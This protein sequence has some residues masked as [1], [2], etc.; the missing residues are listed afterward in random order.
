MAGGSRNT[1]WRWPLLV[2]LVA[3]TVTGVAA[4][5][6]WFIT[7]DRATFL[8]DITHP[9]ALVD[10]ALAT[11]A[12][13]WMVPGLIV[14]RRANWHP[15]GWMLIAT[16]LGFAL[17]FDMGVPEVWDA[18]GVP[19]HW[20]AWVADGWGNSVSVTF[21]AALLTVFPDGI[22]REPAARRWAWIRIV[23]ATVG[24]VASGLGTTV[25]GHEDATFAAA[26]FRNPTGLG[27]IPQAVAG[28]MFLLILLSTV[29][30]AVSLWRR[31]RHVGEAEHGRYT[32]VLFPFALM[33]ASILLAIPLSMVVGDAVWLA[34][35]A[36]YFMVPIAFSIAIVRQRLFDIDRVV[37][38]T[39]TYGVL[40]AVI[41]MV[42][43]VPA[44][45][46]PEALGLSSDLSVALATLASAAVFSPLRRRVHS[47]VERRFDRQRYDAERVVVALSERLQ[48]AVDLGVVARE[49]SS[50]VGVA[51][52]PS[53]VALWL[54]APVGSQV[55]R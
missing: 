18:L 31:S 35:V 19:P 29:G 13:F 15:V 55:E 16:G 7:G 41:S 37:S 38:R 50:A 52:R 23:A 4:W 1:W 9:Q 42:Y 39:V 53:M 3:A 33:I 2:V 49:L 36:M 51:L 8:T 25:G 21:T 44:V 14:L 32:W 22:P 24:L 28:W 46:L 12:L 54:S 10:A 26:Q 43:V 5:W 48:T 30:A 27:F 11:N 40:A 20:A 6:T 34:V 17:S 45:V 47:V